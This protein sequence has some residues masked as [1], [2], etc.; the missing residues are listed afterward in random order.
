MLATGQTS[1]VAIAV[2]ANRVYWLNLGV[3]TGPGGKA[4]GSYV[5]GQVVS[6]AIQGCGN[7]PTVLAS[8]WGQPGGLP[9]VPGALAVDSS[10]V[11]WVGSG[12]V[13][14]CGLAGCG[15]APT[16]I[17]AVDDP[18]GLTVAGGNVY[19]TEYDVGLIAACPAAGCASGPTTFASSQVGPTAV[20][21]DATGIYWTN[22]NGTLLRCAST[23]CPGGPEKLWLGTGTE[24]QTTALAAD[25]RNL[26]WTNGNPL[27]TGSVMQCVKSTCAGTTTVL[28]SGRNA[29]RGIAV[30]GWN[31]Y[32]SEDGSIYE[33]ALG[34]CNGAPTVVAAA[35]GPAVAVDGVHVYASNKDAILVIDK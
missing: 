27:G 34:G 20:A 25:A 32:W 2:D 33:C 21:V 28:A 5:Q 26:Y 22:T 8:G 6:C 13:L 17:A 14:S 10:R 30:D 31:V 24:A 16:C 15:C 18:T 11:Y 35:D 12:D 4:G 3:F 23:S 1:P 9:V 19:W 7:E 29:P